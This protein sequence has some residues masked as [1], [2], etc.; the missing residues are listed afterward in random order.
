MTQSMTQTKQTNMRFIMTRGGAAALLTLGTVL[1]LGAQASG[2]IR[3]TQ[4]DSTVFIRV[5]PPS[6]AM[7]D[8]INVLM[9]ALESEPLGS[10]SAMALRQRIDAL[11]PGKGMVIVTKRGAPLSLPQGWIGIT[12]QGPMKELL[13]D[14]G[15]FIQYFAYPSIIAVDPE[16]PAQKAGIEVGDLLIA[17][18]GLDVRGAEFNLTQLLVPDRKISVTVRREGET[19]DYSVVAARVPER[20]AVRRMEFRVQGRGAGDTRLDTIL[21]GIDAPTRLRML[22][23][24]FSLTFPR[25][26]MAASEAPHSMAGVIGPA[27]MMLLSP[28]GAFGATL[29]SVSPELART[30]KLEVG[31]LVN[32]IAQDTPASRAGLRPGDVIVKVSGQPV[33]SLRGLQSIVRARIPDE[34]V[35]LK[36][37]R[38]RKAHMLIV[39]W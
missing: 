1:P 23:P 32:D 13:S 31:V 12:P 22:Q 24:G 33:T 25:G 29:S 35:A 21:G 38:D 2:S 34:S 6:K 27:R 19:K 4:R 20:I 17:Y 11:V 3:M 28:N 36:V 7:L 26:G 30:L 39:S 37:L 15:D 9:R 14:D 8:S 16:S 10:T 5:A 18:N